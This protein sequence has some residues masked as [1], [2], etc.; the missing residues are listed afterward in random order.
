MMAAIFESLPKSTMF[1]SSTS[2]LTVLSYLASEASLPESAES[3]FSC[4]PPPAQPAKADMPAKAAVAP[5][6][7]TNERRVKDCSSIIAPLL[8]PTESFG[9][10]SR[11][12]VIPAF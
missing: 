3:V 2:P 7:F 6:T 8:F 11:T 10:V 1:R 4:S 5:A 9:G 12:S